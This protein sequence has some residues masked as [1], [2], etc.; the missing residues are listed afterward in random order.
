MSRREWLRLATGCPPWLEASM[1]ILRGRTLTTYPDQ[2]GSSFL[3][4][5][6]TAKRPKPV[7]I[8]PAYNE[9]CSIG[10]VVGGIPRDRVQEIIVVDKGSY[11]ATGQVAETSGVRVV[12]D[13][14]NGYS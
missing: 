7:V 11:D 14:R 2:E 10:L 1:G 3:T 5:D 13:G 4:N 9:E 6:F 12:Y 8:I